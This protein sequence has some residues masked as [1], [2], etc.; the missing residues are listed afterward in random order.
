MENHASTYGTFAFNSFNFKLLC[1][2]H[3]EYWDIPCQVMQAWAWPISEF[4]KH[5]PSCYNI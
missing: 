3:N 4:D 1:Y 5:L 2:T